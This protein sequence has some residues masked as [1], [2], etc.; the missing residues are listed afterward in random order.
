MRI[1]NATCWHRLVA[2]FTVCALVVTSIG[3]MKTKRVHFTATAPPAPESDTLIVGA[4]TNDGEELSFTEPAAIEAID[5][6]NPLLTGWVMST[7]QGQPAEEVFKLELSEIAE[8]RLATEE[9]K[10][11][12]LSNL[13]IGLVI[14]GIVFGASQYKMDLSGVAGPTLGCNP[15]CD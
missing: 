10:P 5:T 15:S 3:C 7:Y 12:V 6:G 4:T 8:Y 11:D 2:S 9:R 1:L 14:L 13:V